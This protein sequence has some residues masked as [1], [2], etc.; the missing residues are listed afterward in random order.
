VKPQEAA[1]KLPLCCRFFF[2]QLSS[3]FLFGFPGEV[4]WSSELGSSK[5]GQVDAKA[6]GG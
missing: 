2:F 6:D 5:V 1:A 3:R 4:V